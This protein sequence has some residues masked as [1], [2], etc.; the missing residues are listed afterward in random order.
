MIDLSAWQDWHE[1]VLNQLHARLTF[2]VTE[3]VAA[4]KELQ[5]WHI[6]QN[7]AH[8]HI[9]VPPRFSMLYL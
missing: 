9:E 2:L 5:I 3:V 4:M 7:M 8:C 1:L 6:L